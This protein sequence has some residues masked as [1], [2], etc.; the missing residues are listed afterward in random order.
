MAIVIFLTVALLTYLVALGAWVL[1]AYTGERL[2]LE[3]RSKL[4]ERAQQLS[5]E[6]HDRKTT[7]DSL[8]R[9]QNDAPALQSLALNGL[10]PIVA[11]AFTIHR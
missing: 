8:Y 1:Q 10:I 5:L 9:I 6:Y 4:F 11:G 2:T 7:T 3:F